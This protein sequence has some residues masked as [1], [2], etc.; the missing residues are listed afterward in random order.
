MTLTQQNSASSGTRA[1]GSTFE[2]LCASEAGAAGGETAGALAKIA[3][4]STF[5][6]LGLRTIQWLQDGILPVLTLDSLGLTPPWVPWVG[7]QQLLHNV[8][9]LPVE[10]LSIA[11]CGVVY[12]VAATLLDRHRTAKRQRPG[13]I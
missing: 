11:F 8:Y 12:I 10:F 1:F 6:P 3:I 9:R 4:F 2:A 5:F 13:T 7:A